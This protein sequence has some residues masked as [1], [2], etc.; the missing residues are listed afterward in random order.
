MPRTWM[1]DLN[2]LLRIAS[3]HGQ[4]LLPPVDD[5]P[6]AK[7]RH[8]TAR[9]IDPCTWKLPLRSHIGEK[10]RDWDALLRDFFP[11]A[12]AIDAPPAAAIAGAVAPLLDGDRYRTLH[13]R[14]PKPL[15]DTLE[16][17]QREGVEFALRRCGG[18]VL[19]GDEMG[20]GK[21]L[22]ALAIA[23]AYSGNRTGGDSAWPLLIV[24][25]TSMRDVWLALVE[26]WL[27]FVPPAELCVLRRTNDMVTTRSV[28][29]VTFKLLTMLSEPILRRHKRAPFR[30]VIFDESHNINYYP[31]EE[32]SRWVRGRGR[33]SGRGAP[34][35]RGIGGHPRGG[36]GRGLGAHT[37]SGAGGGT[38]GGGVGGG[39][40]CGD[41]HAEASSV[42]SENKRF[43]TMRALCNLPE[44]EQKVVL[45][46]GTPIKSQLQ[47][48]WAQ[49]HLLRPSAFPSFDRFRERYC[50]GGNFHKP[51]DEMME[52][53][54][55]YLTS[56]LMVRRLKEAVMTQL[57]KLHRQTVRVAVGRQERRYLRQL[58]RRY[59]ASLRERPARVQSIKHWG[60]KLKQATALAKAGTTKADLVRAFGSVN[61]D[62]KATTA[63]RAKRGAGVAAGG[64]AAA[65]AGTGAESNDDDDDEEDDEEDDVDDAD[66]RISVTAEEWLHEMIGTL[67]KQE[68]G[69][70]LV[71]AHHI[72]VMDQACRMLDRI[73][74]KLRK[75]NPPAAA[76]PFEYVRVDGS[77]D[78]T[79]RTQLLHKFDTERDVRVALL[80]I[81]AFS[82][83]VT[84]NSA[85]T[86]VF[87]ELYP[88]WNEHAQAEARCHRRGQ[89]HQVSSY[90]LLAEGS[91]DEALWPRL[92]Q[93]RANTSSVIDQWEN[94][95][96]ATVA[97]EEE[98]QPRKDGAPRDARDAPEAS[99][100][101]AGPSGF[102]DD[103]GATPSA[104]GA[105]SAEEP[106][107]SGRKHQGRK[108]LGI[109]RLIADDDEEWAITG[110]GGTGG[111]E[112]DGVVAGGEGGGG[113]AVVA[114]E[115]DGLD[116]IFE[117]LSQA[118]QGE[119]AED[120]T[121]REE[122]QRRLQRA[123]EAEA[124]S[125]VGEAAFWPSPWS[126][127]VYLYTVT[128]ERS[129]GA[130]A[131]S[132]VVDAALGASDDAVPAFLR[133]SFD[134]S[135]LADEASAEAV[136][137]S[138]GAVHKCARQVAAFSAQSKALSASQRHALVDEANRQHRP[139]R[140]PLSEELERAARRSHEVRLASSSHRRYAQRSDFE[141]HGEG[142]ISIEWRR[143]KT[144]EPKVWQVQAVGGADQGGGSGAGG[145]GRPA[146]LCL[147]C[148]GERDASGKRCEPEAPFCS[149]GCADAYLLRVGHGAEPRRQCFNRDRGICARC[150]RDC[151]ALYL[152]MKP[153]PPAR[154]RQVLDEAFDDGLGGSLLTLRRYEGIAKRCMP[155]DLWQ[156][157]HIEAVMHGGGEAASVAQFQT[158]CTPCHLAKTNQDR[159][160]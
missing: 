150:D 138:S 13:R 128:G 6:S 78:G 48:F 99:E 144:K 66:E 52:E 125:H 69:K 140:L 133:A 19:L 22:Q 68:G 67:C 58:G 148:S 91:F 93:Q 143:T 122:E 24:C 149:S 10:E 12:I 79:D 54:T 32:R 60:R 87:L 29:I 38:G 64:G 3:K 83:G 33:G 154:R 132:V 61:E 142:A 57:P 89:T 53:L 110:A 111:D 42:L 8:C 84:L 81:T 127:R 96:E 112:R 59:E 23:A 102:L 123:A 160:A 14:I 74:T 1:D 37:N 141:A 124:R 156:A 129:S 4:P 45:L 146:W 90:Y 35:A 100:G 82:E 47:S 41:G 114:E 26:K 49:L 71:F 159:A 7:P 98:E 20:L 135:V 65:G 117:D 151:H 121:T 56:L 28:T 120:E 95:A 70:M 152:R 85:N 145:D 75:G 25:P 18:R 131:A 73:Q 94:T 157:D 72:S 16:E 101:G 21:S 43:D 11:D 106:P 80:S 97:D 17:F 136:S 92:L 116:G 50:A 36:G 103:G 63:K 46:S 76:A 40:S 88:N 104:A 139:L 55:S 155:G 115:E 137:N 105:P 15:R 86:I 27:P 9:Q 44:H 118:S 39:A 30:F 109:T 130:D 2:D 134:A 126:G 108:R 5:D 51:N 77:N 147:Y 119:V 107:E 113:L 158:L 153:L 62:R 31:P 34:P